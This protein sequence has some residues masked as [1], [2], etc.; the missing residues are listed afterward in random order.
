[1][2]IA[3]FL[4]AIQKKVWRSSAANEASTAVSVSLMATELSCPPEAPRPMQTE[5]TRQLQ[6]IDDLFMAQSHVLPVEEPQKT[7]D[8]FI[9]HASE[10]KAQVAAPLA[11]FLLSQGFRVWLDQS[12]ITVGDS[13]RR[14]IDQ[15]LSASSFGI[16]IL[17]PDFLRKGWTNLEL[18]GLI[19]REVSKGKV[20]LPILHHLSPEDILRFSPIL[21][22]KVSVSTVQ[23][24]D[25]VAREVVRAIQL[26]TKRPV[27]GLEE[28]SVWVLLHS[29]LSGLTV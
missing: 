27:G 26:C 19:A 10:D 5:F 17:S 29:P 1:M 6:T 22:S 15:G 13:L 3:N 20:I 25:H 12:E 9:S 4:K 16:V 24:L 8:V 7:Y 2:G 23:G 18:D 28:E 21:A 11:A 14:S